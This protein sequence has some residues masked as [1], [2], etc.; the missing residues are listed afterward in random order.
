MNP[1]ATLHSIAGDRDY[2]S[3]AIPE[4]LALELSR[5]LDMDFARSS[6]VLS[7]QGDDLGCETRRGN[8]ILEQQL[9]ALIERW[10]DC[11]DPYI[12]LFKFYFRTANYAEGEKTVWRAIDMLCRRLPVSSNYRLAHPGQIDWLAQGSDQRHYLFCLKALG[13]IRL[14]RERV[15]LA[16][17]VLSKLAELDPFDEIGGGSF[18]SIARALLDEDGEI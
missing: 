12:A 17:V 11:I 6:P 2:F 14:R 5:L 15:R 18:L 7:E 3:D 10:P 4:A 13:V 8:P 16:Y 9:L 1:T